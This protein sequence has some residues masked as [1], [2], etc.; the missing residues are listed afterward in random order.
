MTTMDHNDAHNRSKALAKHDNVTRT[1]SVIKYELPLD[2]QLEEPEI[3]EI[4]STMARAA[5]T[6]PSYLLALAVES[7]RYASRKEIASA[8]LIRLLTNHVFLPRD[9]TN[10]SPSFPDEESRAFDTLFY[11]PPG[12]L[13]TRGLLLAQLRITIVWEGNRKVSYYI[14]IYESI[15]LLQTPI[16]INVCHGMYGTFPS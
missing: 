12:A 6:G 8:C 10:F 9:L 2:R 3:T 15:G 16:L 13:V 11:G 14:L 5:T 1:T 7:K 4:T